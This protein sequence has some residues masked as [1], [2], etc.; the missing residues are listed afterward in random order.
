MKMKHFLLICFALAL[1]ITAP[2]C[3]AIAPTNQSAAQPGA[4]KIA[5]TL[6]EEDRATLQASAPKP[7]TA[8]GIGSLSGQLTYPSEGIPALRVVAINLDT[9][10]YFFVDTV[11]NQNSYQIQNL[12]A[13]IYNVL[14][15]TDKGVAGGYSQA[16]LC[17]LSVECT[18]H[19]LID[20][21]IRAGQDTPN[22]NPQDWYAPEGE[23]PSDP[24][25]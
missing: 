13:G 11:S 16:V 17:G 10:E 5:P 24:T 7:D 6:D 8:Q 18:D 19:T 2:M 3:T 15:Y 22:V 4:N 12:P 14:A 25:R 9:G 23:F 1:L 21:T 20:I